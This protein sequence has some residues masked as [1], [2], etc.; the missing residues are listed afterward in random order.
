[1]SLP[2]RQCLTLSNK[3]SGNIMQH[4]DI[5]RLLVAYGVMHAAVT[6]QR[7]YLMARESEANAVGGNSSAIAL[8]RYACIVLSRRSVNK[9]STGS[10]T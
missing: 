4:T 6:E 3:H 7:P 10:I 9:T 2:R 8:R 5:P 1:M